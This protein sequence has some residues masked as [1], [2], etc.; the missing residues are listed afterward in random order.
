MLV[1]GAPA[2]SSLAEVTPD[3][4]KHDSKQYTCAKLEISFPDR[5]INELQFSNHNSELLNKN[6][7]F[8]H[9][10]YCYLYCLHE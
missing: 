3:K 6:K 2:E 8:G 10:Y 7:G 9:N 1:K 4:Y 5:E